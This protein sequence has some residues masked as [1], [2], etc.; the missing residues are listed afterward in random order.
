MLHEHQW[1]RASVIHDAVAAHDALQDQLHDFGDVYKAWDGANQ[2]ALNT[3]M[4]LQEVRVCVVGG[5]T[6]ECGGTVST[7]NQGN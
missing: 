3:Q 2:R 1:H 4:Q 6:C 7:T 5:H